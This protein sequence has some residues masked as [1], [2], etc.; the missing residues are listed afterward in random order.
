M[1][2]AG[3]GWLKLLQ[4]NAYRRT[5][6]ERACKSK[7]SQPSSERKG[8]RDSGGRSLRDYGIAPSKQTANLFL[9]ALSFRSPSR[10]EAEGA[11]ATKKQQTHIAAHPPRSSLRR[12]ASDP[13]ATERLRETRR[14][15]VSR[16][17]SDLAAHDVRTN[18]RL[19]WG[20][21]EYFHFRWFA[22]GRLFFRRHE[23]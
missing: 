19:F 3:D 15:S 8:D 11:F 16:T 9:H 1:M 18:S 20:N 5:T 17:R 4:T 14:A 10:R 21:T 23:K 7:I 13:G 6:A 12:I 2:T 22:K